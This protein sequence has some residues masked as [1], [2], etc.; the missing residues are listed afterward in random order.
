MFVKQLTLI[1]GCSFFPHYSNALL[2][3]SPSSLSFVQYQQKLWNIESA[4]HSLSPEIDIG[5]DIPE[6]KEQK[7]ISTKMPQHPTNNAVNRILSTTEMVLDHMHKDYDPNDFENENTFAP[8][9]NANADSD[10]D[11]VYANSYVDLGRIDTVGFDYDYTLV[12]YT[13]ALQEL[14][15]DMALIRLVRD[16]Q[17]PSE[18]LEKGIMEFDPKFSIRGEFPQFTLLYD[19]TAVKFLF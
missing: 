3:R 7:S 9:N 18:M 10:S 15:Y 19:S 1:A 11:G 12:T 2:T 16:K 4:R 6:E 8:W 13:T 17:Y 5:I 14:I